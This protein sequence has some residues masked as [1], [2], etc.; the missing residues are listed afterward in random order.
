MV[1]THKESVKK[2]E[3][4][5]SVLCKSG[6]NSEVNHQLMKIHSMLDTKIVCLGSMKQHNGLEY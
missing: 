4:W 5:L 1:L 6:P 3:I 2:I